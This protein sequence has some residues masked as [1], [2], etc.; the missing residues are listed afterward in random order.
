[1][2][3]G[4]HFFDEPASRVDYIVRLLPELEEDMEDDESLELL[5]SD[6]MPT[7]NWT[8]NQ[9][10]PIAFSIET[11]RYGGDIPKGEQQLGIW[12]AAQWEF[13]ISKAGIDAAQEL[14]F[15]PGVVVNGDIWSFVITTRNQS[16]TVSTLVSV[17]PSHFIDQ[18]F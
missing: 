16:K 2:N 8:T 18:N 15:V 11:K 9:L 1:M 10:L 14:D 17:L 12:N 13:L 6:R 7:L 4:Y 3:L 5:T